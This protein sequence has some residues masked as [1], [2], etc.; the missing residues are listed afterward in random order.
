MALIV[1]NA[2]S[3]GHLPQKCRESGD[4]PGEGRG[5]P[6]R[7]GQALPVSSKTGIVRMPAVFSSYSAKLA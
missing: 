3:T 6:G 4:I 5:K 1:Q 2:M 7:S